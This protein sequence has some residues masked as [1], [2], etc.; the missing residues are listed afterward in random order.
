MYVLLKLP[1]FYIV[2]SKMGQIIRTSQVEG[3]KDED[4]RA[5]AQFLVVYAL[6]LMVTIIM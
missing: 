2:C 6:L 4:K 1:I 3:I 5:L